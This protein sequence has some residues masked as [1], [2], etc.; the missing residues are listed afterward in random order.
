MNDYTTEI[1]TR[2]AGRMRTLA[3]LGKSLEV[4]GELRCEVDDVSFS[5]TSDGSTIFLQLENI[6]DCRKILRSIPLNKFDNKASFVTLHA[7]LKEA[8]YTLY[9][10]NLRLPLLGKNAQFWFTKLLLLPLRAA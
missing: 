4:Q 10:S 8:Q 7:Y 5:M 2:H 9:L 6:F 1:A 3:D